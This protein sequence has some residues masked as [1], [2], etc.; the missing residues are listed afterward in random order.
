ML[1]LLRGQQPSANEGI[2]FLRV[3]VF[4]IMSIV[5]LQIIGMVWSWVTLWRWFQPSPAERPHG[6]RRIRWRVI[7]PL[8]VNLLLGFVITVAVPALLEVSLQALIFVYPDL[9]YAMVASGVVA[10]VWLIRTALAYLALRT[11]NTPSTHRAD[12]GVS[13][14]L[15]S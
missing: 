10:F 1:S 15:T 8:V 9:G 6:W 2:L 14:S 7:P 3:L 12:A 4:A 11:T 5:G 13:E